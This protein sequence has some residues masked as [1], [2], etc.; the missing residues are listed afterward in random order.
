MEISKEIRQYKETIM[1]IFN[2][3]EEEI[4]NIQKAAELMA[5]AIERDEVI[6]VI[7]TGG[8]SCMA[9]EEMFFRAGGLAPINP[10]LDAGVNIIHG[11]KRSMNIERCE[12]YGL[13]V[14]ESFGLGKKP[15]EVLIITNAYGIN[16]MTIDVALEAKRRQMKVIAVTS[17]SF[18]DNVPPNQK[19]RHSSNKNL[20]QIAD[21]FVNCNLPYGDAAVDIEGVELKVAP[22]STFC[23]SFTVNCLVIETVKILVARGINPPVWMSGNMPGGD[24]VCRILEEK[25]SERIK[26]LK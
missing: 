3:I 20:Y 7:G 22:T 25:Y 6:H 23:N 9:V 12:G 26:L 1:G 5:D 11:A 17:K 21:V 24:E 4:A 15:G 13:T 14:F 2:K 19:F 10:V 8:H 18:A 16:P